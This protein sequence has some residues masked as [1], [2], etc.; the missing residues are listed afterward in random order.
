MLFQAVRVSQSSLTEL[1]GVGLVLVLALEVLSQGADAVEHFVTLVTVKCVAL[2]CLVEG[3]AFVHMLEY[4]GG[5]KH[6]I[7]N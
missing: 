5:G 1:T 6:L 2:C 4:R 3:V 7:T